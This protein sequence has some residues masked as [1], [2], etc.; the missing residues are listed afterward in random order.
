MLRTE[1]SR[2][3]ILDEILKVL[4]ELG[5]NKEEKRPVPTKQG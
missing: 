3:N 1:I 4:L 5:V 2:V